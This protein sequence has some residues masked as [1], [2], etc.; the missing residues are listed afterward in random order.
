MFDTWPFPTHATGA[1]PQI[2]QKAGACD[3]EAAAAGACGILAD[4][5]WIHP[6][7]M[8][9]V[10]SGDTWDILGYDVPTIDTTKMFEY[11]INQLINTENDE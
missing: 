2:L 4:G 7:S 5:S 11:M 6:F 8:G 10:F 3:A 9:I 1:K